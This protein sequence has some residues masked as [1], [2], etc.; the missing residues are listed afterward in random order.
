MQSQQRLKKHINNI[1]HISEIIRSTELIAASRL[2]RS[3]ARLKTI[4]PY[5][6]LLMN[7]LKDLVAGV[8]KEDRQSFPLLQVPA[9]AKRN[10]LIVVGGER[11][12]CGGYLGNVVRKV[13]EYIRASQETEI[14]VYGSRVGK[15]LYNKGYNIIEANSISPIVSFDTVYNISNK[16]QDDFVTGRYKEVSVIYTLFRNA[17]VYMPVDFTL[18][19]IQ[20]RETEKVGRFENYIFEPS[21]EDILRELL[22]LFIGVTLYRVFL[23]A[24]TSEYAARRVAM[25]QA[26]ENG[27]ELLESLYKTYQRLRQS[28][29]T[30]EIIEVSSSKAA[31]EREE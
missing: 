21:I 7:L 31:I 4:T 5:S 16:I 29:I 27:K 19:P 10:L 11:G 14:I 3:Q 1:N 20:F 17:F 26:Y 15:T 12:L 23:E 13:Q 24:I 28:S 2:R 22:S 25:H 8:S 18:M 9:E 30:T 6:D